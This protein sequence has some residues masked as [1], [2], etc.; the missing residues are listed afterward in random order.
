MGLDTRNIH[1]APCKHPLSSP[2]CRCL[3]E[4]LDK[5]TWEAH[6]AEPG[7]A[8]RP[9]GPSTCFPHFRAPA[10]SREGEALW[11]GEGKEHGPATNLQCD[12]GQFLLL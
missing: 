5:A 6:L 12:L 9:Q 1:Q 3:P 7:C 8:S 4:P 11:L 10:D 2:M